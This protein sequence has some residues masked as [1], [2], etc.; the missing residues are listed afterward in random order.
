[1]DINLDL[2]G[3]QGNV[4]ILGSSFKKE[5]LE[6]LEK[7][8]EKL[9][10]E[11]IDIEKNEDIDSIKIFFINNQK[12]LKKDPKVPEDDD[13]KIISAYCDY[14]SIGKKYFIT[15]DEHFWGYDD[16]IETEYNFFVI[17]EWECDKLVG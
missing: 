16:L 8:Y 15:E 7:F 17:K 1:M 9:S 13:L 5:M 14:N 12:P 2:L 6:Q 3:K 11:F 4:Q 10:E